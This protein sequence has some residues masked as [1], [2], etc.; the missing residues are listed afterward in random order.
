MA[1]TSA[2]FDG[3]KSDPLGNEMGLTTQ[4]Y[5]WMTEQVRVDLSLC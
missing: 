4:D 3:Y 1:N 5:G 2:G